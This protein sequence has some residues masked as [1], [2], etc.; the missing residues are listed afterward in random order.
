MRGY[1]GIGIYAAKTEANVGTL[2]RTALSMGAAFAFTVKA[3]YPKQSSDTIKSWRH[4]PTFEFKTFDALI[5]SLVDCELVAVELDEK[6]KNIENFN[7]LDRACYL[8][9]AEDAGL[10]KEVLQKVHRIVQLPGVYCHNVA[11]AG[12]MVMYDRWIK[13][14]VRGRGR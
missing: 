10:P 1:Y 9:G 11:V 2:Y 12:A 14:V 5:N 13:R 8:L 4:M 6:A 7:H 3:R